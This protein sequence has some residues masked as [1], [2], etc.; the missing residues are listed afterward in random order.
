MLELEMGKDSPCPEGGHNP[1]SEFMDVS[2]RKHSS[3]VIMVAKKI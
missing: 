1:V 3:E 2:L